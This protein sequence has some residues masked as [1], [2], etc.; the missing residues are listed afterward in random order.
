MEPAPASNEY[1]FHYTGNV[2]T[3]TAPVSGNYQLEAWGAQ[4]G[5]ADTITG[6]K[7]AYTSGTIHLDK[8][9]TI[10]VYVGGEGMNTLKIHQHA[11]YGHGGWNGGADSCSITLTQTANRVFGSG[12]GATDFRLVSGDCTDFESLKS[13]IMVAAGGGGAYNNSSANRAGGALNG[14][15]GSTTGA[16]SQTTGGYDGSNAAKVGIG[17][18]GYASTIGCDLTAGQTGGGGGYYAGGS[19]KNNGSSGGGSSFISGYSG[20]DAISAESTENNIVHTGQ[21]VHYSGMQFTNAVMIDGA[22]TM[23]DPDGSVVTGHAGSGCAR[24]TY[25]E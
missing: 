1:Q 10:Y 7:G 3:F 4:G 18:F 19:H 25:Q 17:Q 11:S 20:C 5:N 14:N 12:G 23:P 13:R 6:G 15:I 21:A 22:S 16:A 8:G 9:D 24:I 2:Q